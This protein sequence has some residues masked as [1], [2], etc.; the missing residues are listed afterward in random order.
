[1]QNLLFVPATPGIGTNVYPYPG[2]C[3]TVLQ[4]SQNSRV[5]GR[6]SYKTSRSFGYGY[7]CRAELKEVQ[8]TYECPTEL[9]EVLRTVIPGVNT[10]PRVRF[11]STLQNTTL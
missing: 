6:G 10:I 3:A 11:V 1:M 2:Y 9:T 7:E 4:N 8:G 5:M